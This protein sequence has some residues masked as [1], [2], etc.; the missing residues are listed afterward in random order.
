VFLIVG[1]IVAV[2]VVA[3][4][5]LCFALGIGARIAGTAISTRASQLSTQVATQASSIETQASTADVLLTVTTFC[6]DEA[7]QDY[8]TAY[9]QLSPALQ[10]QYPQ[11]KFTLDGQHHDSSL[12][13]VTA[14]APGGGATFSGTTASVTIAVT[15]TP[16]TPTSGGGTGATAPSVAT[17]KVTLIQNSAGTWV[18]NSVDSSLHLL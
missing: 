8:S 5:G 4:V 1:I 11:S 17:G 16:P 18:I 13:P 7:S 6:Q 9:Q 10:Q 2:I 3:C 15:R 14:C 12:G